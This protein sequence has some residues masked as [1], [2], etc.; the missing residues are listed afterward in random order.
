MGLAVN[1]G[2]SAAAGPSC[3][4][5]SFDLS[6]SL[7]CARRVRSV[8][9]FTAVSLPSSLSARFARFETVCSRSL[10]DVSGCAFAPALLPARDVP[11]MLRLSAR[12]EKTCPEVPLSFVMDGD[13]W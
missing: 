6:F 3:T 7:W 12:P 13:P 1:P 5:S 8:P 9:A 2:S 10:N 11:R 4:V